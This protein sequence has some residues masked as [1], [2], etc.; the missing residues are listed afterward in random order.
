LHQDNGNP[1]KGV[2]APVHEFNVEQREEKGQEYANC[3]NPACFVH[4]KYVRPKVRVQESRLHVI[5]VF[6]CLRWHVSLNGD[7][8]FHCNCA[9]ISF[10]GATG[11]F[12][13]V[14]WKTTT[15]TTNSLI[16]C[17]GARVDAD[18]VLED[19]RRVSRG[20]NDVTDVKVGK[21]LDFGRETTNLSTRRYRCEHFVGVTVYVPIDAPV[22]H[23]A[24]EY[25]K[26]YAAENIGAATVVHGT[27][28][29]FGV[30]FIVFSLVIA[31][32]QLGVVEGH[33]ACL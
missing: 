12:H 28:L 7:A 9:R 15:T 26:R 6:L 23:N 5:P 31:V 10:F 13:G 4:L 8:V 3:D 11:V 27:L 1:G 20:G 24:Y 30:N 21:V 33:F 2:G 16:G 19:I 25:V 22:K 18:A 14:S 29:E 17:C 32:L